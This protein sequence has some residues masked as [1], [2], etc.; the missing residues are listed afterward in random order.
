M[1]G[2]KR[3]LNNATRQGQAWILAAVLLV[4]TPALAVDVVPNGTFDTD[5]SSWTHT[6]IQNNGTRSH[7]TFHG[8]SLKYEVTGRRIT[9]EGNDVTT[10]NGTIN[11]TD[12]V[13]L[14]FYWYKS[15]ALRIP[16]LHDIYLYAV[17]PGGGGDVELWNN[18]SMPGADSFI[19]GTVTDLDVS[20][21]FTADGT[22]ELKIYHNMR[23]GS[24]LSAQTQFNIDDIVLD[25]Q[26]ATNNAPAVTAGA[27]QVSVSPVNRFGAN[28]TAI[29]TVFSDSDS[30]GVGAFNVTFKIREPD[31]STELTLVNNQPNGG[32]GL[33]ITD[34]GGG[35]Y[36][37]SYTYNPSDVQ[38]TGLYDLYFE[39]TDGTDNIIDDYPANLDE[40][41]INEV[42]P[43]NAPTITAGA[44]LVSVSPVNRYGTNTTVFSTTF[45]DADDPGVGAFNVTFKTRQPDNTTELT[46]VNNQPNGGGGLTITDNGGGSYT[47]SYT[48]N[49]DDAQVQGLYDLYCEVTDGTDNAIDDFTANLDELEINEILPN[50]AP[51]VVAGATQVSVSPVNR[52]GAVTTV[53]STVFSDSDVP[54]VGA[55]NITFKIREPDNSTELTLVN[56]LPNGAGGLT[57]TDQGGGNYTASYTYNPSDIQT[58][59]LYDLYFEVTDGTD[60]AIDDY[61]GNLDELEI[62]E[63]VANNAPVITAGATTASV[64]PVNRVGAATTVIST[65]FSD[66]D[67][68]GAAAFT[69]TL[70]AREP[71]NTTEVIL[72]NA[73]TDG[74]GGLTI[75]DQG[76]GNY[77][78]QYTWNPSDIQTLGFYDL[79]C[80]VSDAEDNA[81]DG[82]AS[83]DNELEVVDVPPNNAP[84]I[85]AGAT[86]VSVSPVNRYGSNS[87]VISTD[88]TDADDPGVSAFNVSFRVRE[89][90]NSTVVTLVDNQPN[91]GGGL[92]ITDNGGGSYTASYTYDPDDAQTIGLY[93]LQCE[94][95]DGSDTATD[96][97][98]GNLDELEIDETLPNNPPVIVAGATTANVNPVNRVGLATTTISTDFTDA[99]DPGVGA[100]TVIFKVREP[101]NTTE[102]TLVNNQPNGG[103]GLTI[104]ANGGG[105]YTAS[106]TWNP[107]DAQTLGLYDMYCEVREG[108]DLDIDDYADNDNEL[109]VVD[110]PP[111]NVPVITAGAT[112]VSV[113]PV[114]RFGSESTVISTSFSDADSPLVGS[115]TVSFRVREPDNTTIVTL[116]ESQSH[117]NGGLTVTDLGSGNYTASYTYD[118]DDAQTIGTYDLQ[119]EVF[120]GSDTTTDAYNSN[121]EELQINEIRP[122]EITAGATTASVNP[123]NRFGTATTVISTDFTDADASGVGGFTVTF[124]V[125]EPD[126]ATELILV[127]AQTDGNGGLAITDHGSGNFTA[128]Y[129]W[130]P[131]DAQT[132]GLYDL[133]CEISDAQNT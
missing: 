22:Y 120:D 106:Y 92:T 62:N 118:P 126:N 100:Y 15:A 127:N 84:V 128:S 109:E 35:N 49:P 97:Y 89:P 91:G 114:N 10:L 111:N 23:S 83:N 21:L 122:P 13:K 67:V 75:V 59:G 82:Y 77:T 113:S 8:G 5:L 70:K 115:F 94:V 44:T 41:E 108:L 85:T 47:A 79:Y 42:L 129:T 71:D 36:T 64:N 7:D 86:Q 31:N 66:A 105:S 131:D 40:L 27:T 48:Y 37:A 60:N 45:S 101:D 65:D 117:G 110:V 16:Q 9:Y 26:V 96:A 104:T 98:T 76:S 73:Q 125:R 54:G 43:N 53:V 52:V 28:T 116:V 17:L 81:I 112:Q 103:G 93:D 90:D 33:T 30:P 20:N 29:S 123:V 119:C 1:R 34:Q 63:V 12:T 11:S 46:L 102:L 61:P 3:H 95:F 74:N 19:D 18:I 51:T 72:V 133:Y 38:T 14:S 58:L 6:P 130:N 25:V 57:I 56:N 39:V 24:H 55:F 32:G 80:E 107:D 68:P 2:A 78:A 88:F 99:D 132:L 4:G 87:T 50:N 124:K 69:V 121:A